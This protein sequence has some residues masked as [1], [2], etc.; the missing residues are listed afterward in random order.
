[1]E[2]LD[3][4]PAEFVRAGRPAL[5]VYDFGLRLD[6]ATRAAL[7]ARPTRDVERAFCAAFRAAWRGDAE[8]DRFSALVLRAGLPWREVAVLRAYARYA[9]QLGSPYGVTYMADTLLAA[10]GRRPRA[11]GAVPRAVRP[12]AHRATAERAMRRARARRRARS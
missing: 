5:L 2:V 9:R 1:M 8:T 4:R 7:A 11:G 12:G 10:P 3:E 6:D